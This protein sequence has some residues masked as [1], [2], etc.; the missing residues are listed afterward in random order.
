MTSHRKVLCYAAIAGLIVM[1]GSCVVMR[2]SKP[3]FGVH[4][5]N[6]GWLHDRLGLTAEQERALVVLE[7]K[8][9]EQQGGPEA[10]I[11]AANRELAE[12]IWQDQSYSERV[13]AAVER[14]HRA[15]GELQRLS[16]AHIFEMQG[17]LAPSQVKKLHQLVAD[18]LTGN[19]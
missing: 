8:F 12:A 17:A 5:S 15:Q 9:A 2:T 7:D 11:R 16:I 18:A 14:V 10:E 13:A 4:G 6:H 1:I 19:L 3:W